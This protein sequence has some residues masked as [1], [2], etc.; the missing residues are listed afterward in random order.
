MMMMM[1]MRNMDPQPR[2]RMMK[3]TMSRLLMMLPNPHVLPPQPQTMVLL[4]QSNP[5]PT[6]R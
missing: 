5:N 6:L 1:A 2:L 4:P 3:S